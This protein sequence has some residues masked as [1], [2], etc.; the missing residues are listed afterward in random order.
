[1]FSKPQA[2]ATNHH[3][4]FEHSFLLTH[5]LLTLATGQQTRVT[6]VVTAVN[7]LKMKRG[8]HISLLL[9]KPANRF[10]KTAGVSG[11]PSGNNGLQ[12]V[13][14]LTEMLFRQSRLHFSY[15]VYIRVTN[16]TI[17]VPKVPSH[18][19]EGASNVP[20]GL[21][22][23]QVQVKVFSPP[24]FSP[25]AP[26]RR[27]P[28]AANT[29]RHEVEQKP[30]S[31]RWF[32]V[33][34]GKHRKASKSALL[35]SSAEGSPDTDVTLWPPKYPPWCGFQ[36]GAP[37]PGC[38][39]TCCAACPPAPAQNPPSQSVHLGDRHEGMEDTAAAPTPVAGTIVQ[40]CRSP[41]P[42][43]SPALSA[44]RYYEN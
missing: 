18:P 34:S 16:A 6:V 27:T 32:S 23:P 21:G 39:L 29:V 19:I 9:E 35:G 25:R 38:Q 41:C 20:A 37:A 15:H 1:M 2:V 24:L 13:P 42:S 44:T 7:S 17:M 4:A 12:H 40:D 30:A 11:E 10:W 26:L 28:C 22:S 31:A 43:I 33:A 5:T 8:G 3:M 36:R 14:A